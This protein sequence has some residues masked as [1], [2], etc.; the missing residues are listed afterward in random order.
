M[1]GLAP[2]D[3]QPATVGAKPE[4]DR[5]SNHRAGSRSSAGFSPW[6]SW[7]IVINLCWQFFRAWMPKM[8]REQYLYDAKQVQYFSIGVLHRGRRRLLV[9][10]VPHQMAGGPRPVGPRRQGRRR[11]FVCSLLTALSVVAAGLPASALLLATLLVIGF[12]SLGQFPTYYAFTQ[13]LSARRMG[14]VTGRVELPDLDGP[15][16]R[17]KADRPLARPDPQV[18]PGHVAGRPDAADRAAGGRSALESVVAAHSRVDRSDIAYE[19]L[20]SSSPL[21]WMILSAG[22]PSPASRLE[23]TAR[24]RRPTR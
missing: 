16:A 19:L 11:F 9:D 17:A 22:V 13:E 21:C 3:D 7:S 20:Q 15:R 2:D 1:P 4:S 10:R 24:D 23:P 8:L 6:R 12:G 5:T 18:C 14:N